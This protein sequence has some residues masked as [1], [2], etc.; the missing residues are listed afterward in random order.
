MNYKE[1][2][3]FED[4]PDL[5][6]T[7]CYFIG[8]AFFQLENDTKAIKMYDKAIS[9]GLDDDY[10]YLYKGLSLR[11]DKQYDKAI[12]AFRT[13]I[14]R[15]PQGQK[16]YTELAN[17]YYYTNRYDSALTY[18]YKAREQKFELGDPYDKIPN[19][20]HTQEKYD[21]ALEEYYISASL[22]DKNDPK[23]IDILKN[24]GLL[25]YT[26]THNYNKSII[27]YSKMLSI[28]PQE[29]DLYPKLIKAYYANE[30]Y[31]KGDSVFNI[32]KTKYDKSELSKDMM[33]GK[34]VMVD[35]IT[36]NGQKVNALSI[37]KR[38]KE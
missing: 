33:D 23:Y 16:N 12:E 17:T 34:S 38:R 3:K 7:D 9:L 21:K 20:Y 14:A 25:E 30:Q 5:T 4:K 37:V 19:I 28:I 6:K 2:I 24:I 11:Y 18:F 26:H 10:I 31:S 36:W 27:A 8:Y 35:E 1:L 15:N 32:L 13:A 29:Y 22:I